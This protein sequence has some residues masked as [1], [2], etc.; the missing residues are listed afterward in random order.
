MTNINPIFKGYQLRADSTG[1][2][3]FLYA[4]KRR[5]PQAVIRETRTINGRL[6]LRSSSCS[7]SS[8]GGNG[9]SGTHSRRPIGTQRTAYCSKKIAPA[10]AAAAAAASVISRAVA[11]AAAAALTAATVSVISRAVTAAPAY[12]MTSR[13]AAAI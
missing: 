1:I 6:H 4:V 8:S 13:A 9:S 12:S 5:P 3:F 2:T 7:G 11:T 10:K